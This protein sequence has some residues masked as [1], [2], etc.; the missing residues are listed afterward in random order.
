M[1]LY[2]ILYFVFISIC[3]I[4]VIFSF[5]RIKLVIN[6][7]KEKELII[8]TPEIKKYLIIISITTIII[9]LSSVLLTILK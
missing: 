8:I 7:N 2:D 6:K 4:T 5:L 9:S 3:F 1:T